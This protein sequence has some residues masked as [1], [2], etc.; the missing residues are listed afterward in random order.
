[1]RL[2][3]YLW[4][5]LRTLLAYGS[6]SLLTTLGIAIG[7]AA[8]VLLTAI[9]DGV[10]R[11]VLD[12]F[13][14][15]GTH[16][17]AVIPG[18]SQTFGLSGAVIGTTRPLTLADAR[19]LGRLP[20]IEA[21]TP[22]VMGNVELE[23]DGRTRRTTLF[24]VGPQMPRV[25]RFPVASGRFLPS[26]NRPFAVLGTTVRHTLLP[27]RPALG[28]RIRIAGQGYRIIGIMSSK[29][30]VLGFD[31]NDAVYVPVE[32]GL[33]L[34]DREGLMEIDLLY[35]PHLDS[36][37]VAR[38]IRRVLIRRHGQEDFTLI[39]QKQMLETLGSV[40]D[41]LTLAVA[42]LGGISLVVGGIGIFT[43]QT[44][45]VTERHSEIG[46]LRALGARRRQILVLF[47][48]ESLSL[49][50]L[51]ATVGV[52][53]GA[54]G[55]WLIAWWVKEIPATLQP[56][57]ALLALAMAVGVGLL[58]GALPAWRAAGLDPIVSLR[59]E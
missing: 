37:A 30:K 31:M 44:V 38:K 8:V 14:Q 9:G 34:F 46:L 19:A 52:L 58:A 12:Q 59:A 2:G 39:T 32:R 36:Q 26:G 25:W 6:R 1:M 22:M 13:T 29:G 50:L 15:F 7:I 3:D 18:K 40:L 54:G 11:F 27:R 42:A 43:L 47:L 45:A 21:V 49:A 28:K 20:E 4:L 16:L 41:V 35:H 56:G 55:A 23:I 57:Y 10:K 24:G 51:G 17:I 33:A 5:I 53:M 48:G